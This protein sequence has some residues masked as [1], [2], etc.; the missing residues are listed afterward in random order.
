MLA[1][2]LFSG[3]FQHVH[4]LSTLSG[5]PLREGVLQHGRKQRKTLESILAINQP[6]KHFVVT[7]G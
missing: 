5:Y 2:Y 6:D 4:E 1:S 3:F 7:E